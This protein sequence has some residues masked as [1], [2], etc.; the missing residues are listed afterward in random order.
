MRA[1]IALEADGEI[2]KR[3][4]QQGAIVVGECDETGFLHEPSKL[5]EM[6][7][8]FS[9]CHNPGPRVA[10]RPS[11]FKPVP[12]LFQSPCRLRQCHQR[13]ATIAG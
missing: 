6:L 9:S 1:V 10:A 11:G 5:D 4:V 8:A 12:R 13:G 7:G 2:E 3:A